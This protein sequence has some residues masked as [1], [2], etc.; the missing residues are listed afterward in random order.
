ML[1]IT[2]WYTIAARSRLINKGPNENKSE[3][4]IYNPYKIIAKKGEKV[5]DPFH[6]HFL[7]IDSCNQQAYSERATFRDDIEASLAKYLDIP[8]IRIVLGE[9]ADK[10]FSVRTALENNIPCLFVEVNSY[11]TTIDYN[12]VV[13]AFMNVHTFI[14]FHFT[15]NH[16]H[17]L[18][19]KLVS[20]FSN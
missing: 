14:D 2:D 6:T 16:F 1:G 5:L 11:P 9:A 13:C 10:W 19:G 20:H 18:S 4:I 7:L 12:R 15:F 8:I 3:F 17:S